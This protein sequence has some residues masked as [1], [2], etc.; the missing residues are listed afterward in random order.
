VGHQ[1]TDGL[2][3][4]REVLVPSAALGDR[5]IDDVVEVGRDRSEVTGGQIDRLASHARLLEALSGG[6]VGEPGDAPHLVVGGKRLGDG[7]CDL[8]GRTGD[9]N[10]RAAHELMVGSRSTI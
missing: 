8:A 7:G 4:G 9:E 10:L 5:E 6:G 3:V 1:E 2:R